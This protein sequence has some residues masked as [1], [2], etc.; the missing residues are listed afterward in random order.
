MRSEREFPDTLKLFCKEV[1]APKAVVVDPHQSQ[2]SKVVKQLLN[3]V[4]TT[5]RVLE[6][7]TQHAE[8]AE[9]YI[10]LLKKAVGRDLRES[11]SPMRLW[12]YCAERRASI[13]TLTANNL[14]QLQGQNPYMATLHDMGDIF[15]L[16]QFGW[17]EWVYFRQHTAQFPNQKSELVRCLE[18]TKNDG[19]EMCQWILQQNGQVVPRR[20]LRRLKPEETLPTN[21]V[22]AAKRASFDV[23]IKDRLGDSIVKPPPLRRS[24]LD[25]TNNFDLVTVNVIPAA[26]VVDA[27]GK[28]ISQ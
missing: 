13:M 12:C 23:E 25:P 19:N 5:L 9:L 15:N 4:R 27:T 10:G 14:Y 22:E 16:C 21:T 8:R 7:S 26:D 20:T 24:N 1:G 28:P 11:N 2:K 3:K 18:P 17:Y 6:E